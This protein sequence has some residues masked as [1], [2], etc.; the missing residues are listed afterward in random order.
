MD[1]IQDK[2]NSKR[3]KD[4]MARGLCGLLASDRDLAHSGGT[5]VK[6]LDFCGVA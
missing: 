3:N 4:W 5:L 2:Q 1:A 6:D